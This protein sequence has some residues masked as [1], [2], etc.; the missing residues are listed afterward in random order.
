MIYIIIA[1]GLAAAC[2]GGYE[3]GYEA[4]V[5]D[6]FDL[7]NDLEE[8]CEQIQNDLKDFDENK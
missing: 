2:Y 5:S 3:F 1:I 6:A 8:I 4:G 7:L